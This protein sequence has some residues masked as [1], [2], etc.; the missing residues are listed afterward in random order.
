MKIVSSA[1]ADNQKIPD[2][3]TCK[4]ED[5]N[6]PLS[7]SDVPEKTKSLVL[8][9]DDS[10]APGGLWT[11]WTV[12]NIAPA[13]STILE[14][15]FP[16]NSVRGIT[17]AGSVGYHGP[18]PPSGTHHYV[19]HLLAL[20]VEFSLSPGTKPQELWTAVDNHILAQA[21]LTGLYS[22]N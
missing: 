6:P 19:F 17:S 2:R 1:F 4:G 5:I 8:I 16:E 10:D 14:N 11:H 12:W 20:D 22:K 9:L 3:Y 15:S 18:C 13:T 7:F 21:R